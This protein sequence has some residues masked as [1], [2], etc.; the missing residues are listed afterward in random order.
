MTLAPNVLRGKGSAS[1]SGRGEAVPRAR[2]RKL[3]STVDRMNEAGTAT[4][5]TDQVNSRISAPIPVLR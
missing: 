2:P 4:R 5:R 3:A 1:L